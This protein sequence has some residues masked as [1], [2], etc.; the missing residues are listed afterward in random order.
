MNALIAERA[1]RLLIGPLDIPE[2]HPHARLFQD[3]YGVDAA[4]V[5]DPQTREAIDID[6]ITAARVSATFP[7]ITPMAR[8]EWDDH[9]TESPY[10][11][12]P[13]RTADGGYYDNPGELTALEWLQSALGG[14]RAE[15]I[16]K[17]LLVEIEA[18]PEG[19]ERTSGYCQ[20]EPDRAPEGQSRDPQAPRSWASSTLCSASK[21]KKPAQVDSTYG[22]PFVGKG[23]N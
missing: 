22:E 23:D 2:R 8:A 16:E 15:R 11:L 14:G 6:V 3:V 7:Y 21:G 9:Q 20:L 12:E 17:V 19:R 4:E 5:P 18:F 10:A 13:F 1:E